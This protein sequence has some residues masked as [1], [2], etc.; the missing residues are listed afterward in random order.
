MEGGPAPALDPA[1]LDDSGKTL[2]R[3]THETIQKV[4][5]DIS[6]RYT[7][8]TA[9]AAV[10]ELS[11]EISRSFNEGGDEGPARAVRQEALEAAVLLLSPIVPHAAHALWHA[12]GHDEAVIDAAWPA[13]DESALVKDTLEMVV[14]VNGKVRAKLT[15][16]ANADKE[17][18]EALAREEANVV[19]FTEGK[20]IRKVIVVPGKL[21]NIVAN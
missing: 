9:I 13:V 19:R 17:S 11:N 1:T 14:Q 2:R 4:S 12:L 15:V 21:V 16:P 10:M 7:F 8:N 5:D 3:K 18:V 20:T 6:R